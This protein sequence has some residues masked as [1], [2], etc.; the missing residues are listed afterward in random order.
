MIAMKKSKFTII[1][2]I[3]A[4]A[5]AISAAGIGYLIFSATGAEIVPADDYKV[6]IQMTEKY[7][8]AEQLDQLIHD[9]YYIPANE[10]ELMTGIY[11]GLF[12]GLNDPYSEYLTASEYEDLMINTTGEFEG[13]GVTISADD[14][15]NI[16]VVSTIDGSPA[17]QA[18]LK[19]GDIITMV[20][21]IT[22]SGN[23]LSLA[24]AAIRGEKGTQVVVTY[25]R[26]GEVKELHI[27]RA[28]IIDQTVYSE[29]LDG[30]IGY[31]R[32]TQFENKTGTDFETELH[33][34][35]LKGVKGIVVDIRNNGGG[36]VESGLS[37]ADQLLDA[38]T[39]TYLENNKG[40]KSYYNS[41]AGKTN[42]PYV[43]LVNGGTASTSEILAAAVMDNDGGAIVGT[44]T[45]GKGVVQTVKELT[46]GDAI[47][48]TV[49]QY[50][51]PDGNVIHEK[52]I[53]PDYI[54][55]DIENNGID[56]QLSK[57]LELLK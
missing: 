43:L 2:I 29:I 17:E 13:I 27:T 38:G 25:W 49:A 23:D 52:G 55:E 5:G 37:T 42:V 33:E 12:S 48:I 53:E 47:K 24:A 14:K 1:I 39:I 46:D 9:E 44:Q 31:I 15:D 3:V 50:Y 34:L 36:I 28:T 7:H 21:G 32:I 6:M 54:V 19:T 8:K 18:G 20:D 11:K 56:E 30:N 22:Y 51:S 41:K 57:A 10:E 40:E 4:L 35:E 16:I 45:F 26:A